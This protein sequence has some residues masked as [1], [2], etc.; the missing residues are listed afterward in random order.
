MKTSEVFRLAREYMEKNPRG[1]NQICTA[2]YYLP[3]V[4]C[5]GGCRSRKGFQARQIVSDRLGDGVFTVAHWARRQ[6]LP[7]SVRATADDF[8]EFRI[9]WLKALEEEF[10]AKGD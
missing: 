6:K 8:R 4:S 7:G 10:K 5:E 1:H 9:R 3:E 2:I